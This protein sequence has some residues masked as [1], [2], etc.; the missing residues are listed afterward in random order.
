VNIL[1]GEGYSKVK[2][3]VKENVKA[4]LSEK[5]VLILISFAT[6]IQT[7]KA[8]PQMINIIYQILTANDREQHKDN[9]ND[10]VTKYLESNKDNILYLG[11]RYYENIVDVFTNNVINTG[12]ASS[13]PTL[14]LPQSSSIFNL[15]PYNQTD[16]CRIEESESFHNSKGDIAE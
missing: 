8:D 11:E 13:N 16:R 3:I 1:N 5:R 2:Q 15:G 6:V 9:S 12:T 14:L 10:N 4:V 7:L